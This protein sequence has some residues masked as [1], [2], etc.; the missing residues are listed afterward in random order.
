L[1]QVVLQRCHAYGVEAERKNAPQHRL[2]TNGKVERDAAKNVAARLDCA[3][4]SGAFARAESL[5][6]WLI[7]VRA[8]AVLK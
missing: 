3:G 8:K 7:F 1:G 5:E 2:K 4:F 6:R